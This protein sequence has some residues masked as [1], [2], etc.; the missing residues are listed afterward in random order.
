M[1]DQERIV[2]WDH[3][4]VNREPLTNFHTHYIRTGKR[5]EVELPRGIRP[6]MDGFNGEPN[7]TGRL[8]ISVDPVDANV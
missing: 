4:T 8:L 1:G 7:F 5:Q 6:E 3:Y 2:A